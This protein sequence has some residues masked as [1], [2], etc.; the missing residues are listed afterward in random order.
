MR[1]ARLLHHLFFRPQ[2]LHTSWH[3]DRRDRRSL[4][5]GKEHIRG[6]ALCGLAGPTN[7]ARLYLLEVQLQVKGLLE[8]VDSLDRRP[9]ATVSHGRSNID[10]RITTLSLEILLNEL[11]Y[12]NEAVPEVSLAR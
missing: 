6:P 8:A 12:K 1:S 9:C 5:Q 2:Q 7:K 3:C 4:T 10:L 11:L